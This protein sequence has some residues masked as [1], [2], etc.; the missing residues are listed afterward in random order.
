M[1]PPLRTTTTE[2]LKYWNED[3]RPI[4]ALIPELDDYLVPHEARERFAIVPY[5][6]IIAVEGAKHLWVGEPAVYRVLSEIVARVSPKS[7]PLPK[8]F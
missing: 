6:E 1:S 8:E 2:Q 7:L 5:V 3:V 4:V